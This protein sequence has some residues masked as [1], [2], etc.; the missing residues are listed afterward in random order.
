MNLAET[1]D[2]LIKNMPNSASEPVLAALQALK[3]EQV[4]IANRQVTLADHLIP[5]IEELKL[6][7]FALA[8]SSEKSNIQAVKVDCINYYN[9]TTLTSLPATIICQFL[10]IDFPTNYV[11]FSHIFQ[12][13]WAKS[14]K[15]IYLQEINDVKN[16]LLLFKPI[17]VAFDE[18]RICFIWDDAVSQFRMKVLDPSIRR[19]TLLELTLRQFPKFAT[20]NIDCIFTKQNLK[21]LRNALRILFS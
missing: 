6:E 15:I 2:D 5:F 20:T 17:E 4:A 16:L 8:A 13:K 18:G 1:Y 10:G 7:Q 14:R 11:N 3:V 9:S 21:V 19:Q 12:R